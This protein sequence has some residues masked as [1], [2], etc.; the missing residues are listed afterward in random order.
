[1]LWSDFFYWIEVFIGSIGV[2]FLI[3]NEG[4]SSQIFF[5]S[6]SFQ[7]ELH[8]NLETCEIFERIFISVQDSRVITTNEIELAKADFK[9]DGLNLAAL[10][11]AFETDSD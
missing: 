10:A 8:I 3:E 6:F 9:F 7:K 1:M 4:Q 11:S 5:G 2:E